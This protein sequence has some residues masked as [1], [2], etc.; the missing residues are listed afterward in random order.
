MSL[1]KIRNG[2]SR[3]YQGV[4]VLHAAK[5]GEPVLVAQSSWRTINGL[6]LSTSRGTWAWTFRRSS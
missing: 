3:L 6:M 1:K 4:T 5:G 2:P